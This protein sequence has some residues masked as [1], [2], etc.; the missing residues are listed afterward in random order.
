MKNQH[1]NY[2]RKTGA[3]LSISGPRI[4]MGQMI[5]LWLESLGQLLG[6]WLMFENAHNSKSLPGLT[7]ISSETLNISYFLQ[8]Y[9]FICV[10]LLSPKKEKQWPKFVPPF[11]QNH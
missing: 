8:F 9:Y 4:S 10:S 11:A 7:R 6:V 1:E 2:F 5:G 3:D